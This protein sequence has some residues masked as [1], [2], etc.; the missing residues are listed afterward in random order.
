VW[1]LSKNTSNT[2]S[3]LVQEYKK[4][5]SFRL[6]TTITADTIGNLDKLKELKSKVLSQLKQS[7]EMSFLFY[8]NF[9]WDIVDYVELTNMDFSREHTNNPNRFS[10]LYLK[11][12]P[13]EAHH[14]YKYQIQVESEKFVD[15][16]CDR[17]PNQRLKELGSTSHLTSL[18]MDSFSE[19]ESSQVNRDLYLYELSDESQET[20]EISS[21]V[22]QTIDIHAEIDIAFKTPIDER[23]DFLLNKLNNNQG[24][25]LLVFFQYYMD[26][27]NNA[28]N[29][30]HKGFRHFSI[31][32]TKDGFELKPIIKGNLAGLMDSFIIFSIENAQGEHMDPY[33]MASKILLKHIINEV[34]TRGANKVFYN[35]SYPT[36]IFFLKSNQNFQVKK[37]N[38]KL[39]IQNGKSS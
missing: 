24:R 7:K 18:V 25:F 10:D 37:E 36:S 33:T 27:V 32:T 16:I 21:I 1:H 12:C 22:P 4:R 19:K 29:A 31:K 20:S 30:L 14:F 23:V 6:L 5:H 17:D 39:L 35:Y 15:F 28:E 9:F 26:D 2:R 3:T 34:P 13:N 11:K 38:L 8:T